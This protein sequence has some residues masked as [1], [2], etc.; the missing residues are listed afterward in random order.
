MINPPVGKKL[1]HDGYISFFWDF[2]HAQVKTVTL[3]NFKGDKYS[4]LQ[5][6][7]LISHFLKKNERKEKEQYQKYSDK[8]SQE[9]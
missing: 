5:I 8:Q 7:V 9:K 2:F 4:T 1:Q 6:N 3:V